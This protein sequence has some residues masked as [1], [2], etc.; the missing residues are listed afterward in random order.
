MFNK[1]IIN[2]L[3]LKNNSLKKTNNNLISKNNSLSTTINNL[4]SK[5]NSLSTELNLKNKTINN[6]KIKITFMNFFLHFMNKNNSINSTYYDTTVSSRLNNYNNYIQNLIL[7]NKVDAHNLW[8]P[9]SKDIINL[10]Q[11]TGKIHPNIVIYSPIFFNP[12]SLPTGNIMTYI[13]KFMI[14]TYSTA[15]WVALNAD[16]MGPIYEITTTY[17]NDICTVSIVPEFYLNVFLNSA[18]ESNVQIYSGDY[19]FV[20]TYIDLGGCELNPGLFFGTNNTSGGGFT[21]T[22]NTIT[23]T[24]KILS[25]LLPTSTILSYEVVTSNGID[26]GTQTVYNVYFITP[27]STINTSATLNG[28]NQSSS[29]GHPIFT[30]HTYTAGKTEYYLSPD[31][32]LYG[33]FYIS[34]LG[35]SIGTQS[36]PNNVGVT[37]YSSID[38]Y[39]VKNPTT[40]TSTVYIIPI[41]IYNYDNES[42][43][44]ITL[45]NL[46]SGEIEVETASSEVDLTGYVYG[47]YD[48]SFS[49]STQTGFDGKG[50]VKNMGYLEELNNY[51]TAL[52]N[53]YITKIVTKIGEDINEYDSKL[54]FYIKTSMNERPTPTPTPPAPAPSPGISLY[55]LDLYQ[56]LNI[57]KDDININTNNKSITNPN[58]LAPFTISYDIKSNSTNSTRYYYLHDYLFNK[59]KLVAE[60]NNRIFQTIASQFDDGFIK[61]ILNILEK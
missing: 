25:T 24:R 14:Y 7:Q 40:T 57:L 16:Y 32:G 34:S 2:S 55:T 51:L 41:I 31:T 54:V 19:D 15:Q 26:V 5:N 33:T 10:I 43:T 21:I 20:P 61:M 11:K 38:A 49:Y 37:A 60:N 47:M 9:I 18:V 39:Y 44:Y 4:I 12:N 30:Y 56:E 50:Y 1:K 48:K 27:L 35:G 13:E 28:N 52:L 45:N 23:Y 3:I 59:F 17:I 29:T 58:N 42:E 8:P 53:T 22:L 36:E 46:I 6:D